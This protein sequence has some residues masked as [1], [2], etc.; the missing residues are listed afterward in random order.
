MCEILT[1]KHNE[2]K[3]KFSEGA[4]EQAFYLN[5]DGAGYLILEKAGIDQ[6]EIKEIKQYPVIEEKESL[7]EFYT[8]ALEAEKAEK[9]KAEKEKKEKEEAEKA[10]K[11]KS[12]ALR[13]W[14]NDNG[15]LRE[16]TT[17]FYG[18]KKVKT[19]EEEE[20]EEDYHDFYCGYT[21]NRHY[22][23]SGVGFQTRREKL[24]KE[25]E[26]KADADLDCYKD[27]IIDDIMEHQDALGSNQIMLVHFRTATSGKNGAN[28]Q[29]ID[30]GNYVVIH[31]GVLS[32]EALRE[33]DKDTKEVLSDT[34][35]FTRAISA[36]MDNVLENNLKNNK[37]VKPKLEKRIITRQINTLSGSYSIFIY[38]RI[39][40]RLYY[41]K[42]DRTS[43]SWYNEYQVLG[44]TVS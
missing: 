7:L 36:K 21:G 27:F 32:G 28:T 11:K 15:F 13:L 8:E 23:Q 37:T 30:F 33:L 40:K 31:N 22:A 18:N 43:F 10:E 14:G 20:R 2:E 29:P 3:L 19:K 5:D 34:A 16:I 26:K 12:R 4:F 6:W 44:A 42:N 25:A 41:Y 39:T 1:I 38:S 9:E 17:D 35:L 24:K